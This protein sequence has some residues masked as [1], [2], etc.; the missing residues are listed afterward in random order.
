MK[1]IIFLLLAAISL[2]N[3]SKSAL[4]DIDIEDPQL[5]KVKVKI[6][7]NK[8]NKKEVQVFVRDKNNQPVEMKTGRVIINNTEVSFSKAAVQGI[9][10]RGYIYYPDN[11]EQVFEVT[12]YWNSSDKFNFTLNPDNGWPGFS[13]NS[14][15]DNCGTHTADFTGG[16][17]IIK[18]APFRSNE[19]EF[20]YTIVRGF[21]ISD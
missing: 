17:K 20:V 1:T 15:C 19:V 4:S 11:E 7:Q 9:Q 6:A 8:E 12:I 3:C 14:A 13:H 5:I 10:T 16:G 21:I 2:T 18:P